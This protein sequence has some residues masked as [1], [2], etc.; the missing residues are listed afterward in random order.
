MDD[1]LNTEEQI[2][3]EENLEEALQH[4]RQALYLARRLWPEPGM[5]LLTQGKWN[6]AAGAVHHL[7]GVVMA[8]HGLNET[9]D[10]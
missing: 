1:K 6:A 2:I 10:E 5:A 9:D 8:L 4:A 3:F 7:E